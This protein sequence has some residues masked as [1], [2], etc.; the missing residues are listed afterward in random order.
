MKKRIAALLTVCMMISFIAGLGIS[1]SPLLESISAYLNKEIKMT[2]RGTPWEAQIDGQILYPITYEDS[3][4][5]PVR[6]VSEAL[7]IPI[8]W[9]QETRSVHIAE[10][11]EA[12]AAYTGVVE[13]LTIAP[14]E[15]SGNRDYGTGGVRFV[16]ESD[17]SLTL[18]IYGSVNEEGDVNMGIPGR[19][20][21]GG[22]SS[23]ASESVEVKIDANGNISGKGVLSEGLPSEYQLKFNGKVLP[24]TLDLEIVMEP[25]GEGLDFVFTYELVRIASEAEEGEEV[26]IEEPSGGSGGGLECTLTVWETRTIFTFSDTMQMIMVPVCVN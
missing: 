19:H 10:A 13:A 25:E 3:T 9:D 16:P 4:Y 14:G 8:R 17:G 11:F 18:V 20:D 23:Q 12:N 26:V 5:L 24:E 15:T 6:A 22:W 7:N 2:L 21:A 1:G